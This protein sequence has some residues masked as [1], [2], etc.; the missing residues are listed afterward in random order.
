MGVIARYTV[1]RESQRLEI[2]A[3]EVVVG[4]IIEFKYGN[5]FPCDGLLIR[6]NDVAVSESA[7]TGETEN[8]R[9]RPEKDPFLY[10]GTQVSLIK[11]CIMNLSMV[12]PVLLY[13]SHE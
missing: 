8:I 12:F 2:G 3:S 9:K 5:I 11:L 13:T 1:I 6:G 10:A 4:D 7:L